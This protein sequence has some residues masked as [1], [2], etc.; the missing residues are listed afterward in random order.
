M[1]LEKGVTGYAFHTVPVA[2][3]ACPSRP[4]D[5]RWAVLAAIEC[6]GDTDTVAAIGGGISG[7][8]AV[9]VLLRNVFFLG[10][11]LTHGLRRLLPPY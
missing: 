11:V 1:G 8:G 3:H 4:A 6:G 9:K 10:V 7:A 5:Y 2:L